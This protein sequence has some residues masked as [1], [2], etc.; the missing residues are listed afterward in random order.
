MQEP[1]FTWRFC[2]PLPLALLCI[3]ILWSSLVT[4]QPASPPTLNLGTLYDFRQ[5]RRL[6]IFGFPSL[7]NCSHTMLQQE[8]TVSTFR[9]EVLRYSLVAAT[10]SIYYCQLETITMTCGYDIFMG[11]ICIA[12]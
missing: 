10:F 9:G 4:A 7:K 8:A 12:T 11:K 6:G 5:P 1:S 3:I 2:I